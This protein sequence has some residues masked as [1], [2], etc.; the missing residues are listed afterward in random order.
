MNIINKLITYENG[1]P[2]GVINKVKERGEYIK[3]DVYSFADVLNQTLSRVNRLGDFLYIRGSLLAEFTGLGD[4]SNIIIFGDLRVPSTVGVGLGNKDGAVKYGLKKYGSADSDINIYEDKL[5][6]FLSEV[7][8]NIVDS[9]ITYGL[10]TAEK[11]LAHYGLKRVKKGFYVRELEPGKIEYTDTQLKTINQM[12]AKHEDSIKKQLHFK[13]IADLEIETGISK[14]S[15][16]LNKTLK[17]F[18]VNA[19][20]KVD[21]PI[22]KFEEK[23]SDSNIILSNYKKEK[24]KVTPDDYLYLKEINAVRGE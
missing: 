8:K 2:N 5:N 23:L 24:F 15:L 22:Y 14:R 21:S 3:Q 7:D 20:N 9:L 6:L 12:K 10:E 11:T 18:G 16:G 17:F 19:N 13:N 1:Y 4:C